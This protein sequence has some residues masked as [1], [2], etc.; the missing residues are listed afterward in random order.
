MLARTVTYSHNIFHIFILLCTVAMYSGMLFPNGD[1]EHIEQLRMP[2]RLCLF[3]WGH[4]VA[5]GSNFY[6]MC[7]TAFSTLSQVACG[8]RISNYVRFRHVS[9]IHH[10]NGVFIF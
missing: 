5:T 10:S 9:L 1:K 6:S 4:V 3:F 7:I 2:I 8:H